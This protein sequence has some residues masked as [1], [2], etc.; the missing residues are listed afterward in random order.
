MYVY[1]IFKFLV[2]FSFHLISE[3]RQK[4]FR[5][6]SKQSSSAFFFVFGFTTFGL[7]VLTQHGIRR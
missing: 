4:N 3:Y 6:Y 7:G 2:R 1:N 5:I